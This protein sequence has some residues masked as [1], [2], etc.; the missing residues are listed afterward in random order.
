MTPFAGAL[1][2]R[3]A[4][5]AISIESNMRDA[6]DVINKGI[7]E[8]LST[9]P[10]GVG[11]IPDNCKMEVLQSPKGIPSWDYWTE[12]WWQPGVDLYE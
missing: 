4:P 7:H 2:F 5:E 8:Y 6:L 9:H 12:R 3:V 1:S 11:K 10:D